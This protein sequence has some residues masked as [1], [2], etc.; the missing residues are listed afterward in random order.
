MLAKLSIAFQI[1]YLKCKKKGTVQILEYYLPVHIYLSMY[2]DGILHS[3]GRYYLS[4][5]T[6]ELIF[7]SIVSLVF[8]TSLKKAY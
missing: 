8:P 5:M 2:E 3:V 6:Q 1:F 4:E 7:Y